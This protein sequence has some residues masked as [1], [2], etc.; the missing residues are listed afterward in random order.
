MAGDGS[1]LFYVDPDG[2]LRAV[3]INRRADGVLVP[4]LPVLVNVPPIGAGHWGTQDH[5]S[6]DGSR[7]TTSIATR[8]LRRGELR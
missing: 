3:A 1:E 4:R 5:V 7:V 2:A 8:P 6:P